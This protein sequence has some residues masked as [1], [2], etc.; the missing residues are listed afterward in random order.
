MLPEPMSIVEKGLEQAYEVQRHL[1]IWR[2]ARAAV[3][4]AGS[5]GLLATLVP[6]LWSLEVTVLTLTE[7]PH[8]K[9]KSAEPLGA[10]YMT[11]KCLPMM[12]ATQE[13]DLFGIV[14][15]AVG[16]SSAAFEAWKHWDAMA[17]WC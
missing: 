15:E 17:Y 11:T 7:P 5:L 9:S 16:A 10:R 14:F 1:R 3:I 8:L 6:R 12:Q 4:G 13:Y 2:T